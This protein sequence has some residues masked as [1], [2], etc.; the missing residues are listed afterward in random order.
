MTDLMT[1]NLIGH[2]VTGAKIKIL[3]HIT[4]P[5]TDSVI[6]IDKKVLKKWASNQTCLNCRLLKQDGRFL[7]NI[8]SLSDQ[9]I[10]GILLALALFVLCISLY[11][12]VKSLN[13]LLQG[14]VAITVKK[15]VNPKFDNSILQY[16][17][18]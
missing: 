10:G 17:K 14:S 4:D 6:E 2:N 18:C 15:F 13:S 5:L 9:A 12:M 11:F 3:G 8:P 16:Q 1:I 7:F